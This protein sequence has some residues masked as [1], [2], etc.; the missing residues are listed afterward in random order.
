VNLLLFF[1]TRCAVFTFAPALELV[2]RV[3]NEA[4]ERG[5][6]GHETQRFFFEPR[7]NFQITHALETLVVVALMRGN[8]NLCGALPSR[9]ITLF[10]LFGCVVTALVL[11]QWS[12]A[13]RKGADDHNAIGEFVEGTGSAKDSLS[14]PEHLRLTL[15][16]GNDAIGQEM[17]WRGIFL[18]GLVGTGMPS[19]ACNVVQAVSFGA[20]HWHGVP[21]GWSGM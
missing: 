12:E 15:L 6:L 2:A 9:G 7:N 1:V 20:A 18:H 19:S 16:S 5:I 11:N 13:S 17:V 10:M 14:H 21:S 4:F 8:M 3:L